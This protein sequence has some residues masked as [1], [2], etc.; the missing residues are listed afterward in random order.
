MVDDSPKSDS[1]H[2]ESP[3]TH[4][5]DAHQD[6]VRCVF[7]D[8]DLRGSL[9]AGRCPECGAR[10]V[11]PGLQ[12]LARFGEVAWLRRAERGA[13]LWLNAVS[14]YLLSVIVFI[15]LRLALA[16][17]ASSGA[18]W[19]IL[20]FVLF[21]GDLLACVAASGLWAMSA[22]HPVLD[23]SEKAINS[24]RLIRLALLLTLPSVL[25]IP[26]H[27][28]LRVQNEWQFKLFI[29]WTLLLTLGLPLGALGL[30]WRVAR[31]GEVANKERLRSFMWVVGIAFAAAW[32]SGSVSVVHPRLF[33]FPNP[34]A[35][36]LLWVA[37]AVF[38]L[39]GLYCPS[40]LAGHFRAAFEEMAKAKRG[41]S[42]T[43]STNALDNDL[44]SSIQ[45]SKEPH[46]S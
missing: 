32:L 39:F 18:R 6:A 19:A 4:P 31:L 8:Y 37:A 22:R 17:T 26:I 25:A 27:M 44:P 9:A 46:G 14:G 35:T 20:G 24:R 45:R 21:V 16:G 40:G 12:T 5:E 38:G 29:C 43:P 13:R 10:I 1:H 23:R 42:E 41:D 36:R 3:Q 7:C 28:V 30:T 2:G 34:A 11:G 33:G 15:P